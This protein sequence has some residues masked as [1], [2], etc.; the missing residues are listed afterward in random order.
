M[1]TEQGRRDEALDIRI[2]PLS[3]LPAHFSVVRSARRVAKMK[4]GIG[5]ELHSYVGSSRPVVRRVGTSGRGGGFKRRRERS[6][7]MHPFYYY[8]YLGACNTY[9]IT[10]SV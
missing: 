5:R 3:P 8:Y 1:G 6:G 2:N 7:H 4:G 10:Y 9:L